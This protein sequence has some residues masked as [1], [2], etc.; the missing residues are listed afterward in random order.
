MW[1]F[2]TLLVEPCM[3]PTTDPKR[4]KNLCSPLTLTID[5]SQLRCGTLGAI[6]VLSLLSDMET[7]QAMEPATSQRE[8]CIF[9]LNADGLQYVPLHFDAWVTRTKKDGSSDKIVDVK[10]QDG[11]TSVYKRLHQLPEF[12][13]SN[14]CCGWFANLEEDRFWLD[15]C[16][17]LLIVLK[18]W[19]DADDSGDGDDDDDGEDDHDDDP[20]DDHHHDCEAVIS[21]RR[22]WQRWWF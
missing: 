13:C 5:K 10:W 21:C 20:D 6:T 1:I 19:M 15:T 2:R 12:Q 7:T 18:L 17:S 16:R 9:C 14:R 4:H 8:K 22:L 3:L 11:P